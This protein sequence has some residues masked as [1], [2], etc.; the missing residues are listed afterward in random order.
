MREEAYKNLANGYAVVFLRIW[1]RLAMPSAETPQF[2]YTF[3]KSSGTAMFFWR[4][5]EKDRFSHFWVLGEDKSKAGARLFDMNRDVEVPYFISD[6]IIAATAVAALLGDSD[7]VDEG[8]VGD[9]MV[10]DI[11]SKYYDLQGFDPLEISKVWSSRLNT[12]VC[13][14]WNASPGMKRAMELMEE[15]GLDFSLAHK[16]ALNET[17]VPDLPACMRSD[18]GDGRINMSYAGSFYYTIDHYGMAICMEHPNEYLDLANY[19]TMK[20]VAATIYRDI[21]GNQDLEDLGIGGASFLLEE[22]PE[23]EGD[24]LMPSDRKD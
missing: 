13:N 9:E 1:E 2:V 4:W 24:N 17:K 6:E 22:E 8:V 18:N 11:L 23:W 7:P 12:M 15:R 20:T 16:I 14:F 5:K 3:L 19:E 21:I 10:K